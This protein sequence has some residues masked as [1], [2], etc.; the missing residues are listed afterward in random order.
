MVFRLSRLVKFL[1]FKDRSVD[2]NE[3]GNISLNIWTVGQK[4]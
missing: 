1:L 3:K 4:L 2:N